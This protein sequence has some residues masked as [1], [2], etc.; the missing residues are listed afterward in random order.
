MQAVPRNPLSHSGAPPMAALLVLAFVLTG[1][2]TT[3]RGR[4]DPVGDRETDLAALQKQFAPAAVQ[5]CLATPTDDCRSKVVRARKA[6]EDIR[7]YEFE[8]RVFH[9]GRTTGFAATVSTMGLTTAAAATSGTIAKVFAGLAAMITGTREAYEK[10]ILAEK[11]LQA[12]FTAMR[13]DR[14]TVE[15]RIRAGLLRSAE[16]YALED[17]LADLEAY[18]R[19][20][21]VQSALATVTEVTAA[22]TQRSE[23]DLRELKEQISFRQFD[24]AAL[25]L[26]TL[27]CDAPASVCSRLS[28][29]PLNRMRHAC[30]PQARVPADTRIIDFIGQPAFAAERR[31]VLACMAAN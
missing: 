27:I 5:S 11:T 6:A 16:D 9:E 26:R 14:A 20:G 31:A 30:W 24:A 1:C 22:K 23:Q 15:L 3:F 2:G 8:E 12:L 10:E 7:F 17:G 19:A 28:V 21:T 25:K 18:R 13:G 29:E 4:P